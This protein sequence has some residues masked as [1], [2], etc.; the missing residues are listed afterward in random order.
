MIALIS[1][2]VCLV[3]AMALLRASTAAAQK[4]SRLERR[5]AARCL[6]EGSI[7]Y[8]LW[9]YRYSGAELPIRVRRDV[10]DGAIDLTLQDNAPRVPDTIRV[11]CT[12]QV[13]DACYCAVLIAPASASGATTGRAPVRCTLCDR[14][15]VP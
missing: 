4:A 13:H 1:L 2:A 11:E 12:A 14:G 3:L 7:D 6:A 8:G 9:L 5:A 10:G 15:F